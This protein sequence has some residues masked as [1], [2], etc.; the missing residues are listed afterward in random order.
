[1][2][3]VKWLSLYLN[4]KPATLYAWAAQ[5]KIP[6]VKIHGLIRFQKEEID[7]WI[8]SFRKEGLKIPSASF[9]GKN[10]EDLDALIEKAKQEV[11][12]KHRG[13]QAHLKSQERRVKDGAI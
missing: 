10:Y 2:L 11:Y 5:G 4:I 13:N 12:N 9:A 6:Y 3:D 7:A 8:E 1:M